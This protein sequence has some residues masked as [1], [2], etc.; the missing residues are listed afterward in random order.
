[1]NADQ[2][3][4]LRE[5]AKSLRQCGSLTFEMTEERSALGLTSERLDRFVEALGFNGIGSGWREI[6]SKAAAKQIK[7]ILH[8]DLAYSVELMPEKQAEQ[9]AHSFV[10][11]LGG[12]AGRFFTN[13][14]PMGENCYASTP[15][16]SATFC[17]GIVGFRGPAMAICWAQDED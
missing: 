11:L 7:R 2:F 8:R 13:S 9:I 15:I 1:M 10:A 5:T 6:T 16:S 3:N 4:K 17:E 14:E 12:A